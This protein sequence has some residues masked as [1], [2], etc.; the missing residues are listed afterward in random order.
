[1]AN[2]L[3]CKACNTAV[4]TTV[5][6]GLAMLVVPLT[7]AAAAALPRLFKR[8]LGLGSALLQ[9]ALGIGAGYLAQRYLVPLVQEKVCGRCGGAAVAAA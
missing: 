3:W 6:R 4:D 9:G 8:R 1:M 2:K 7:G 5:T